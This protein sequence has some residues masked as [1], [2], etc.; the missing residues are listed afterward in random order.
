[1]TLAQVRGTRYL[2]ADAPQQLREKPDSQLCLTWRV[3]YS[4]PRAEGQWTFARL[5]LDG[6]CQPV[7][8]WRRPHLIDGDRVSHR[9]A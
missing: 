1:M 5:E 2:V 9:I 6:S 4:S 8:R 7:A 3:C